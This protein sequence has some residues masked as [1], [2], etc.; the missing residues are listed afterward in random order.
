MPAIICM[1]R[2]INVVGHNVIKMDA[3]KALFV[4]I[5][6]KDAQTFIQSGNVIFSIS[7]SK[8]EKNDLAKLA[9]RI[10]SALEKKF[11]CRPDVILR[12]TSELREAFKRNPFAKRPDIHPGKLLVVFLADHPVQEARNKAL[13]LKIHPE[14]MHIIGRE[15]YIYFIDGQ[16]KS[17]LRLPTVER[18]LKISGT[19]RNWNS[20]TTMLAIAEKMESAE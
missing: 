7:E 12:T 16:G 4:S 2:G 9:K 8:P 20:V 19:G 6:L 5:K 15:A 13:A 3:L 10:Q 18:A 14:E 1:L 17:K 11:G